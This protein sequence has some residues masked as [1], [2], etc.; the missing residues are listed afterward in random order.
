[1]IV[2]TTTYKNNRYISQ[3]CKPKS[4]KETSTAAVNAVAERI[5]SPRGFYAMPTDRLAH[6]Q[7]AWRVSFMPRFAFYHP[8]PLNF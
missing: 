7:H 1:M 5:I 6:F 2:K 4:G 8:A 3:A